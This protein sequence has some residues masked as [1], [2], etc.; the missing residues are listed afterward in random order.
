MTLVTLAKTWHAS[1]IWR[2]TLKINLWAFC[3]H[4]SFLNRDVST[5]HC[6]IWKNWISSL[7]SYKSHPVYWGIQT[8][9][10][11]FSIC[12]VLTRRY[13]A[14]ETQ[15]VTA[16]RAVTAWPCPNFHWRNHPSLAWLQGMTDRPVVHLKSEWRI[17][18]M[19]V[20][21]R[22]SASCVCFEL[23]GR[24]AAPQPSSLHLEDQLDHRCIVVDCCSRRHATFSRQSQS[25]AGAART[26]LVT[27]I[28]TCPMA[29]LAN[30]W[31][32]WTWW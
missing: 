26:Q 13:S 24:H 12:S 22:L 8:L 10:K 16:L 9:L 7:L 5:F 21:S 29:Y 14:L 31:H 6:C 27:I 19:K 32:T 17:D 20:R 18:P 2:Q 1:D 28:R 11:N 25:R 3:K 15:A 30:L 4:E 23:S